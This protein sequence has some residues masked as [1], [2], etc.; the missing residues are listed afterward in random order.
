MSKN[1]NWFSVSDLRGLPGM[2]GTET[3]VRKRAKQNQYKS[4]KRSFGKG[5]EYALSSLPY[6]TQT[7]L[8]AGV[9]AIGA[10]NELPQATA[11]VVSPS[12][13][14]EPGVRATPE[15]ELVKRLWGM[16]NEWAESAG[17]P[18][19]FVNPGSGYTHCFYNADPQ[20]QVLLACALELRAV[21][22]ECKSAL[23]ATPAP[24]PTRSE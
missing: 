8:R 5:L 2:P 20:K 18:L 3:G 6:E 12:S 7:Y 24:T 10:P 15:L 4:R 21:L 22:S 19:A 16:A 13:A 11:S 9:V 14:A 1:K 17:V 23:P